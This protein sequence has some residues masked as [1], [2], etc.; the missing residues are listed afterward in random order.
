MNTSVRIIYLPTVNVKISNH[1]KHLASSPSF[2][3][4]NRC[5]FHQS[6]VFTISVYNCT[7]HKSPVVLDLFA[8]TNY[9]GVPT[10]ITHK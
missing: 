2:Y 6:S 1:L 9:Y 7:F 4:S 10:K 8:L 5:L 3:F